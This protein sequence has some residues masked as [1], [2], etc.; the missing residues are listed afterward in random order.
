VP[1]DY[2]SAWFTAF[3]Q[4]VPPSQTR[5]EVEFVRRH[6][7]QPRYLSILDLCCGV[8]RHARP[9][10]A[11]GYQVLG[12]DRDIGALREA[13][14][15][16]GGQVPYVAQD[17]R[18]LGLR[19]GALDGVLSLWQS[20]GYFD[21]ATNRDSLRQ[22]HRALRPGGRL[23]LD[24]YHRGFFERHQ[25]TRRFER[26]G[27]LITESKRLRGHRLT[28]HLTYGTG[29][30]SDSFQWQL[31]TPDGLREFAHR[32][33]FRPILA[34]SDFDEGTPPVPETPRMQAIF[35]KPG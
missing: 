12:I 10:A 15:L 30:V 2:S 9:L 29:K 34:C 20:F 7:P 25:G 16:S 13:R 23:V 18:R 24:V 5:R 33:G 28:V 3:L 19:P 6:L 35:A 22:I 32:C 11:H 1:N 17:M 4:S 27:M 26:E 8:G 31:F 14:R 21:A